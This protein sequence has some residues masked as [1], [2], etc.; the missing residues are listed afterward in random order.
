MNFGKLF[1]KAIENWPAKVLCMGLAIVLY[2]FHQMSTLEVRFFSVP[3]NI[4]CKAALMPSSSY[5]RMV[6]ITLRGEANSIYPI[7][8]D[9]IEV[10]A[11]MQAY[12]SPG[13][14]TVPIQWR[15]KGTALG[16]QPLQVTVDPME[17]TLSLDQKISKF[18]PLT[19]NF[20][21]TVESGYA[22]TSYSL[23][24]TQIIIDGPAGLM[25]SI[26]E[27]FTDPIDLDGRSADFTATVN[28]LNRDPL[29]VIRGNGTTEFSG[30]ISRII[31]VR[32]INNVPIV[33]TNLKDGLT[34]ELETK[35]GSIHLEGNDQEAVDEFTPPPDFLTVDCSG[36]SEPGT[37]VLKVITGSAVDVNLSIDPA[38]IKIRISHDGEENP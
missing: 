19:A 12:S 7:L 20:R 10:Y 9:D 27:L 2:V 38:E 29:I 36:I 21:G 15:K 34:G 11:D 30:N 14:Y 13:S 35:T 28:I 26:F 31:P 8:E 16:V 32:N 4:E 25:G 5:P 33:I 17:I 22:L 6:R 3:L 1:A 18:V 23:N 24:P 37:Y